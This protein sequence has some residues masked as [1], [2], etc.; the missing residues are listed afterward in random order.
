MEREKLEKAAR[1][2]DAESQYQLAQ[3]LETS[4]A[5]VADGERWYDWCRKAAEQGHLGAMYALG[6]S[7]LDGD[8]VDADVPEGLRWLEKAAA[9]KDEHAAF[10][11]ALLYLFG[12]RV[13]VDEDKGRRYALVAA[14]AGLP[15]AQIMLAA[16]HLEDGEP[17]DVEKAKRWIGKAMQNHPESEQEVGVWVS[18]LE[19]LQSALEELGKDT[20]EVRAWLDHLQS[21]G[22][23]SH[24]HHDHGIEPFVG[25][26]VK[27]E[28]VY[29]LEGPE[30]TRVTGTTEDQSHDL[31][32]VWSDA[33]GARAFLEAESEALS[34]HKI[35]EEDLY[36]FL[37]ATLP[38]LMED[39]IRVVLDCGPDGSGVDVSPDALRRRLFALMSE[40]QV[41]KFDELAAESGTAD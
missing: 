29:F 12:D 35:E 37:G 26:A 31:L 36:E 10:S 22:P 4:G 28:V 30:G 24:D 8:G 25:D 13:D 18:T 20:A 11:L 41:K 23:H 6:T 39:G 34:D 9:E 17:A 33:A 1:G 40:E 15:A 5:P 19:R 32:L 3:L 2:G 16:E 38:E 7:L 27:K 14:E 21:E